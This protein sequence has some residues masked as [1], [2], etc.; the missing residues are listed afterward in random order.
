MLV[1]LTVGMTSNLYKLPCMDSD[2]HVLQKIGTIFSD[3]VKEKMRFL[4]IAILTQYSHFK[5]ANLQEKKLT[6]IDV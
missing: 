2:I 3:L 6:L 1:V 4:S 5:T